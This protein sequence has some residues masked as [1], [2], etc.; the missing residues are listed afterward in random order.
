MYEIPQYKFEVPTQ[1]SDSNEFGRLAY[2]YTMLS[3]G[4]PDFC[5]I[6]ERYLRRLLCRFRY[7]VHTLRTGGEV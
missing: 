2:N 1:L 5:S 7:Y 4:E 6:N 3:N